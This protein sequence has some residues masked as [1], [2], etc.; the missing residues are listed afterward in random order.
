MSPLRQRLIREMQLRQFAPGT[1]KQYLAAMVGL[2]TFYRRS[3]DQLQVE[4]VRSY[5][6]HLLVGGQITQ[7]TCNLKAAA[8][9]FFYQH[10]LGQAH[11][12]LRIRRKHTGQLPEVYSPEELVRLFAAT[13]NRR[14]RVLLMTTYAAG[15]R[16]SEVTRLRPRDIHAQR[17]LIRVVQGKGGKDRYTLLSP[18]LL[19]ELRWYWHEYRPGEWL[20]ANRD[21]TGPLPP[22]T[23]QLMF[24]AAKRRAGLERGR[25]IHTL[26]H[27]FATHLLEAGVDLR[28]I[29]IL[30]GHASIHS[31]IWYLHVTRKKLD[32]TQNPLDLLDLSGL[33]N[34][35]EVPPCQPC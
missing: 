9:T 3:P 20:F 6:H 22:N 13:R 5:L 32:A 19:Q 25:G 8:L 23:A 1:M 4:E 33:H 31:T 27:C 2:V 28:T 17:L 24:M 10:V 15:L 11:F 18:Q 7:S 30:M 34:F 29:Q 35:Q 26:R 21:R 16:V 12:N 14:Q